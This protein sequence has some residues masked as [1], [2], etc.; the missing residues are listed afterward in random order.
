MDVWWSVISW[1]LVIVSA[2]QFLIARTQMIGDLRLADGPAPNAGRV[3]FYLG[4]RGWYSTC[5]ASWSID[6]AIV[7]CR[8]LGF[9]G[10]ALARNNNHYR[11]GAG[12][13]LAR[14]WE[15]TGDENR[16][17]DC[18]F[19]PKQRCLDTVGV[20]CQAPGYLGCYS[21]PS[22]SFNSRLRDGFV[23]LPSM[24]VSACREHCR[25]SGSLLAGLKNGKECYC[26][27]FYGAVLPGDKLSDRQCQMRCAGNE[28]EVCGGSRSQ[29]RSVTA[30]DT[31]SVFD[32]KLGRCD[33]P[34]QLANGRV[35]GNKYSYGDVIHFVCGQGYQ[36]RNASAASARCVMVRDGTGRT[37][38]WE[39]PVPAC[40]VAIDS[41][42]R[43]TQDDKFTGYETIHR[44]HT[45]LAVLACLVAILTTAILFILVKRRIA[46][47]RATRSNPDP[48]PCYQDLV[49]DY[50]PIMDPKTGHYPVDRGSCYQTLKPP[51]PNRSPRYAIRV[52]VPGHISYP[53]ELWNR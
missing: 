31:I 28:E 16:L 35:L 22:G 29:L 21:D 27:R 18:K 20:V 9:P 41:K 52:N 49:M 13:P 8:Q 25:N 30:L 50:E 40:Q 5:D 26:G 43:M 1:A 44:Q 14:D 37:V 47:K 3:E 36:L 38:G 10:A 32:V 19:T 53:Q 15:C 11:G 45:L 23:A 4:F 48:P 12:V 6:D 51:V 2:R 17:Q 42:T 33:P 24:N 39:Q 34:T 7:V 46:R